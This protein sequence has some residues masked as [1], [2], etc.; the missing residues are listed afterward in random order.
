[1]GLKSL[2]KLFRELSIFSLA[3]AH[4]AFAPSVIAA[5]RDAKHSAHHDDGKFLLVFLNTL[6]DHLFSREK[7]L[8]AFFCIS[9]SCRR[10]SFSRL[11]RRFSSSKTV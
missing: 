9:R 7:M 1:M 6:R 3:L 10:I 5:L 2:L 4:R 8:M 11:R